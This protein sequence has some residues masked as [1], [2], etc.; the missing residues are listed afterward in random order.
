[1]PSKQNLTKK[2]K[3][4]SSKKKQQRKK[5]LFPARGAKQFLRRGENKYRIGHNTSVA[6]A[7]IIQYLTME[8][9]HLSGKIAEKLEKTKI[10]PRHIL[11]AIRMD[12]ELN[13]LL[14]HVTVA[15]G[16]ILPDIPN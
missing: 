9:L 3:R 4:K 7:A 15:R 11:L 13:E 5:L 8:V 1:M 2:N 12:D 6:L 16:G 14:S 10:E